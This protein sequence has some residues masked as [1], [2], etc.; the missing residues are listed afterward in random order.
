[1]KAKIYNP[2]RSVMQSGRAR[3]KF[4]YLEYVLESP[5]KP[6]S[7][8]GWVSS[9]DTLNAVRLKFSTKEAAIK[10]AEEKGIEYELLK[11]RLRK[12]IPKNYADNFKII[13]RT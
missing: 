12:I 8:I 10:F 6:D 11:P 9:D 1:M 3:T 4:W 13:Q 2:S 7:L 5:R